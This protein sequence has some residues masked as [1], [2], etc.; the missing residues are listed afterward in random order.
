LRRA[1]GRRSFEQLANHVFPKLGTELYL[2]IESGDMAGLYDTDIP[3]PEYVATAFAA[4]AMH[5][6]GEV[7]KARVEGLPSPLLSL[8]SDKLTVSGRAVEY[9]I[10]TAPKKM[11]LSCEGTYY[12]WETGVGVAVY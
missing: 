2:Y 12:D 7:L 5:F 4:K 6:N 9:H 10:A 1:F 8:F 11:E 3:T